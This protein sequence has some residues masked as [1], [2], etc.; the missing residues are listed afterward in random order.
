MKVGSVEHKTL[1]RQPMKTSTSILDIGMW[2]SGE[3]L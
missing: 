2:T 3:K 1:V